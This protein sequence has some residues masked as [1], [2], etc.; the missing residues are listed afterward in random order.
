MDQQVLTVVA[1]H[2]SGQFIQTVFR[3]SVDSRHEEKTTAAARTNTINLHTHEDCTKAS[4]CGCAN[5]SRPCHVAVVWF[6]MGGPVP[7][8]LWREQH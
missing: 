6:P 4:T 5:F 2:G 1:K 3:H 8:L 7:N